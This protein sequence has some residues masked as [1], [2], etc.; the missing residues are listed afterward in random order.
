MKKEELEKFKKSLKIT[1]IILGV[2]FVDKFPDGVKHYKDTA[3]TAIARTF[4]NKKTIFFNGK[5]YPQ[6]CSGAD[7]FLKLSK[8]ILTQGA[9]KVYTKD[10][11]VFKNKK[12]CQKYLNFLPKFPD[13]L[14]NKNIVIKPFSLSDRPCVVMILVNPAQAGRILGLLNYD[15]YENIIMNP[16]QPT[17]IS[18]FAPLVTKKIHVNF[19]DYYDRYYQGK[20]KDKYIWPEDKLILSMTFS[21]FKN[22]IRYLAKSAHGTFQ[23]LIKPK[24][25]GYRI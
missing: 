23:P 1:E 21:H 2:F 10:E 22:I 6:L 18:L 13:K 19:I 14:R 25:V 7:Y 12:V 11:H 9:I 15:V 24:K 20:I 8:K 16:C 4:L 5:E 17:C 3:C